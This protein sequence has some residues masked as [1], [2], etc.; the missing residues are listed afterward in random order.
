MLSFELLGEQAAS[1]MNEGDK[2]AANVKRQEFYT[3][4]AAQPADWQLAASSAYIKGYH[5]KR[6]TE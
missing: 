5:A 4:L 2:A 1:A 6:V 3:A